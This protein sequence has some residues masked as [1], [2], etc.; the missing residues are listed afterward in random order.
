MP[1]PKPPTSKALQHLSEEERGALHPLLG[2]ALLP[3]YAQPRFD[4]FGQTDPRSGT[5]DDENYHRQ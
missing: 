2:G 4:Y 1:L 3:S 5:Q